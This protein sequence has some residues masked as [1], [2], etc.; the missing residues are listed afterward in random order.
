MYVKSNLEKFFGEFLKKIFMCKKAYKAIIPV[1]ADKGRLTESKHVSKHL[2]AHLIHESVIYSET[3]NVSFHQKL[4][5]IHYNAAL[6]IIEALRGASRE[7][8]C[9]D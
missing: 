7:K 3:Y 8:L 1:N 4:V 6:A 5:S 2:S 9:R